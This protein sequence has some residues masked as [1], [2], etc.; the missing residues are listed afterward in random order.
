ME[1]IIYTESL[2]YYAL[3]NEKGYVI[4]DHGHYGF[5]LDMT[6]IEFFPSID[7]AKQFI[8]ETKNTKGYENL[9]IRKVKVID[10]G[11]AMI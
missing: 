11:E 7:K 2:V 5:G 10:I 9:Q 8:E 4:F 1:Y 3:R 6:K